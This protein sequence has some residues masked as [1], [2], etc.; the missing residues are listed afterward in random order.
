MDGVSLI[1]PGPPVCRARVEEGVIYQL[2]SCSLSPQ[3]I[4][5]VTSLKRPA[6]NP[7]QDVLRSLTSGAE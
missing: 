3:A 4:F 7:G 6:Y 5:K 1:V 2:L